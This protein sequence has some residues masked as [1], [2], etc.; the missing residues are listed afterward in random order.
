MPGHGKIGQKEHVRLFREYLEALRAA[1]SE[2]IRNGATLEETKSSVRLQK[3]GQWQGYADWFQENL[4]GMY[5]Y[6]S[7]R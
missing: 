3:Y 1:V 4:E 5:R 6:L 7:P 2:Q